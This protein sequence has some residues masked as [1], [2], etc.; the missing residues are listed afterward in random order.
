MLTCFCS[1]IKEACLDVGFGLGLEL[2]LGRVRQGL[3]IT[4][5]KEQMQFNILR[6]MHKGQK[7]YIS[8]HLMFFRQV[9]LTYYE[10][11]GNGNSLYSTFHYM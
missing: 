9:A 11:N 4:P 2:G 6:W 8:C 7:L 1:L 5:A 3:K 10:I